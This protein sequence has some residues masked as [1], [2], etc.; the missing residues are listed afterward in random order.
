MLK[1]DIEKYMKM[2]EKK[3]VDI[4]NNHLKSCLKL[5]S[6]YNK[7]ILFI[8]VTKDKNISLAIENYLG[9][10]KVITFPHNNKS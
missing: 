6:K 9:L 8:D 7:K 5:S 1:G 2:I 10:N 3:F 4:Y